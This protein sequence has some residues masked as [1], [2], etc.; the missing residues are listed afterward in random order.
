MS[1][2]TNIKDGDY[3]WLIGLY[4]AASGARLNLLGVDGGESRIRLGTLR[5]ANNGA[6]VTFIPETRSI[7]DPSALNHLHLNEAGS[8]I[9]FGDLRTDGSVWLRRDGADWVLKTWPR[10]RR[11]LLELSP[12]R[13]GTPARVRCTG[14]TTNSVIPSQAG[15]LW[16]LPLNGS[17]E[18]RWPTNVLK[19][20]LKATGKSGP[21]DLT[22]PA[23]EG[24]IELWSTTNLVSGSWQ[25]V[26]DG[27]VVTNDLNWVTIQT[28]E[29]Q[30]FYRLQ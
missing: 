19:L 4:D 3:D 12:M 9:D 8:A 23:G 10:A 1:V 25:P 11:F 29:G 27:S 26:T 6:S 28:Q 18:Y 17:E 13:F 15:S 30:R 7:V 5:L 16:R 2:G 22:W 14:G 20:D 21:L 24:G